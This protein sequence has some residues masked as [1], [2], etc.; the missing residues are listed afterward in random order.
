MSGPL[1]PCHPEVIKI[2]LSAPED[3]FH[4]QPERSDVRRLWQRLRR[5]G[6]ALVLP[7]RISQTLGRLGRFAWECLRAGYA[8]VSP[9]QFVLR[10]V[11]HL[12]WSEAP[13]R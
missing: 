8:R 2:R 7:I 13:P 12:V 11:L 4:L 10:L 3:R 1:L 6:H 5:T 9:M